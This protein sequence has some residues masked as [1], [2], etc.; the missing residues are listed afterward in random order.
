[1]SLSPPVHASAGQRWLRALDVRPAAIEFPSWP[2]RALTVPIV[3]RA[4]SFAVLLAV[5]SWTA[6][7]TRIIPAWAQI[8]QAACFAALAL[9]LLR[10]GRGDRR[11]WSLGL[12]V[13]DAAATLLTPFVRA[14][15]GPSLLAGAALHLRTDAFQAALLWFFASLFPRSSLRP[16][17]ARFF[18][19]GTVL[20]FGLGVGLV[21][22]DT[23]AQVLPATASPWRDMALALQRE[24]AGSGDWYFTLQFVSLIPLLWLMPR[25]LGESGPDDR[26]RFAWLALGIV[27]GFLPL[28]LNVIINTAWPSD[29]IDERDTRRWGIV[30]VAALTAVPIAG[31]HAALVQRTLDVRLVVRRAVQYVLARSAVRILV[32]APLAGV[33][34]LFAANRDQPVL[35]LVTGPTGLLLAT[36]TAAAAAAALGRRQLLALLDRRFFRDQLESRATLVAVIEAVRAA[37]TTE[38]LRSALTQAIDQAFHPETLVTAIIGSDR[39]FHAVDADLLPLGGD[40]ALARLVGATDA[41]LP[42]ASLNAALMERLSAGD[43]AWLQAARAVMLVPMRGPAGRLLGLLALGEKASELPYSAEDGALLGAAGSAAG[44]VLERVQSVGTT[45]SGLAAVADPPARECDDC[46]T[47]LPADA[48]SCRCGGRLQRAAAPHTLEDR[49]R[50]ERRVGAGAMGVV[51]RVM[52]LRL[53]Q[54]RAVK[55]LSGADPAMMARLRREA[56]AMASAQHANLATLHGVEIWRGAPMLVMEF[57]EGGTLSDRL[58][59]GPLSVAET[60][61]LGVALAAALEAIHRIHLLHRDVKPSNIGFTHSGIPKLLD[62]GLAKVIEP[63]PATTGA[64]ASTAG[65]EFS[66]GAGIHGTPAYLSPEVLAGEPPAAR[67]D[68]WSLSVTLLE[69]CTGA[70]PF[71]AQSVAA[72]VARVSSDG[73]RVMEASSMLVPGAQ[74][75]FADLL[76][77]LSRRP[78]TARQLMERLIPLT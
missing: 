73:R 19:L 78:A 28:V 48:V 49:L 23:L 20:A 57:L 40:S 17:L 44:I 15:E 4:A 75:L 3:A 72:T 58:R 27:V 69:A 55:T 52:D 6:S 56:R 33:L 7:P 42:L 47:V 16:S 51:Y 59:R 65:I 46:G 39:N 32:A 70:N 74:R 64:E 61:G 37:D 50:F 76:G 22:A 38:Q 36:L 30:I 60:S 62:F 41:P 18:Y 11:A 8:V 43:H 9:L 26:R 5:E 2:V 68:V 31:V 34:L 14:I 29:V 71:Q 12:F 1:M 45:R 35:A 66:S 24:S 53:S 21:V 13:L 10:Y 25:K 77:P 63:V 54:V 67:D